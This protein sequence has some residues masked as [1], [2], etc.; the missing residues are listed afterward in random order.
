[1]AAADHSIKRAWW[2]KWEMEVFFFFVLK[3]SGGKGIR[4]LLSQ[5]RWLRTACTH[6]HFVLQAFL[7]VIFIIKSKSH[8]KV[9]VK[10]A[11][12]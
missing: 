12:Q 9:S 3:H 8:P 6:I 2:R 4:E 11:A 7:N 5:S 1:M 10:L